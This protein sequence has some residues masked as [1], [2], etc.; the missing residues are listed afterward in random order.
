MVIKNSK[1]WED[2]FALWQELE[3]KKGKSNGNASIDGVIDLDV[4]EPCLGNPTGEDLASAGRKRWSPGHKAT[5]ADIARHA[6]SLAFQKTFK[7]LM[8]KTEEAIAEKGDAKTKRPPPRASLISKSLTKQ[9][10]RQGSW[11]L[12][13]EAKARQRPWKPRPRQG[14]WRPR[15][16][17]STWKPMP[18]PSSSRLKP[19]S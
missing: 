5:K 15:P 18:R 14:S 6:N 7:E 9:L 13:V 4:Q 19:C 17:P 12:E 11:A 3:K 2:S 10:P 16:R 8:V 1:K